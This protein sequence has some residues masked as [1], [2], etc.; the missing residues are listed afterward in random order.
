MK[1]FA[2]KWPVGDF[3]SDFENELNL[4]DNNSNCDR[5]KCTKFSQIQE[6]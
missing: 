4:S 3:K 1:N 5:M 6:L 2:L